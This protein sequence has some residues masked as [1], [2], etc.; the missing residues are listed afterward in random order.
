MR[1][2]DEHGRSEDGLSVFA[3]WALLFRAG[4][5]DDACALAEREAALDLELNPEFQRIG[6]SPW[7]P[8][9]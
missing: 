1:S 9:T 4:W 2:V 8:G 7:Y 5:F 6:D 3:E